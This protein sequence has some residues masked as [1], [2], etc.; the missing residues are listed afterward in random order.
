MQLRRVS[1]LIEAGLADIAGAPIAEE[2]E[3]PAVVQL[4]E[5]VLGGIQHAVKK[6]ERTGAM[7]IFG[8]NRRQAGWVNGPM[9][10]SLKPGR[11]PDDVDVFR[12][13]RP[14]K[15]YYGRWQPDLLVHTHPSAD[16]F[17]VAYNKALA[18]RHLQAPPDGALPHQRV[19]G[20]H[21]GELFMLPTENDVTTFA[22][23]ANGH[24]G[25]IV[26]SA[27][28]TFLL[29]ETNPQRPNQRNPDM[30]RAA[31]TVLRVAYEG[32]TRH[33]AYTPESKQEAMFQATSAAAADYAVCYFSPDPT[34]AQLQ[35]VI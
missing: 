15:A 24:L 20:Q 16:V 5:V 21:Y 35:R 33:P 30:A 19:M 31:R 9:F 4:P 34:S 25:N 17:D 27:A 2:G 3:Y 29:L 22:H 11:N 7:R 1:N 18:D 14:A 6:T 13:G 32:L 8:S 28:G 23:H 10:W 12:V 26:A